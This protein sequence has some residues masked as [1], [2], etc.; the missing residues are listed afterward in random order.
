MRRPA[1]GRKDQDKLVSGKT[2]QNA[3]KSM[4]LTDA[5]GRVV[6]CSPVRPGSC[7]NITRPDSWDWPNSWPTVRSWRSSRM[8]AIRTWGAD[9]RTPR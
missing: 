1:A 6:F 2:K 5:E 9:R 7:A 8:P 3:V 4:V